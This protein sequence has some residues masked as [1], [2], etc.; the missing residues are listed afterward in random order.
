[1]G[2][3]SPML[4]YLLAMLAATILGAVLALLLAGDR[5]GAHVAGS[6]RQTSRVE[7]EH[8]AT[9]GASGPFTLV[10][11]RRHVP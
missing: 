11:A 9:Q 5:A 6:E 1:M 3:R 2:Q 8:G 4:P 7:P 10:A